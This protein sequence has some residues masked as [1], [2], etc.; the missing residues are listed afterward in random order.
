MI[1]LNE[2]AILSKMSFNTWWI[3]L[4]LQCINSVSYNITHGFRVMGPV[5]PS[6]Y[7]SR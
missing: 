4:I 6:R 2:I 7:T 1:G 5:I 3:H